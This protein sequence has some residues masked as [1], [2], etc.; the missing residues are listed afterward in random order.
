MSNV[1]NKM[2]WFGFLEVRSERRADRHVIALTG[3]LDIDGADRVTQELLRA[4]ATDARQI[5][6]DLSGLT[7]MDSSGIRLIIEADARSRSNGHRLA[8]IRG[9][10]AVQRALEIADLVDRLPFQR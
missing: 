10:R 9:P 5:V 3:E 6:L 7:F 1:I 4:E 2:D 8:L